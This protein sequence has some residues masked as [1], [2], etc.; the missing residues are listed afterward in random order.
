MSVFPDSFTFRILTH[1]MIS[2]YL[3]C[4][5][6]MSAWKPVQVKQSYSASLPFHLSVWFTYTIIDQRSHFTNSK[7]GYR[8]SSQN[9]L[10]HPNEFDTLM[11]VIIFHDLFSHTW[12][13]NS[14]SWVL[15]VII[16][17][18]NTDVQWIFFHTE[19]VLLNL[20]GEIYS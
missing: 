6:S 9:M 13:Y 4:L 15:Q 16:N 1:G 19:C 5:L 17:N 10:D 12:L 7:T 14:V 11:A 18:S 3:E 8:N 2:V 20:Q